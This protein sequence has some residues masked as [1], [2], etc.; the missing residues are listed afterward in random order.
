[1][2]HEIQAD[3]AS[4]SVL[5]A[6]IRSPAGLV[7]H[8]AGQVFE[9]WG[10]GGHVIGDYDVALTD[11]SG[12]RYVGSFDAAIPAGGYC[13]QVFC[14]A[15]ASPADT[16]PLVCSREIRWTGVGEVTAAKLLACKAIQDKDTKDVAY[17]DDDGQTLLLTHRMH[18]QTTT[19]TRTPE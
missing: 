2:A 10:A 8:P 4:G 17:Y 11:K 13:I 12:S 18:E 14:Q 16:D 7:W 6:I 9:V 19:S 5:Y 1:M 3:Y 15:G